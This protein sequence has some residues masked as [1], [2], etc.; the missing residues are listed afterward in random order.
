MGNET[1]S[2][3][4]VQN[5]NNQLFVNKSTINQMTEQLNDVI[6]NTIVKN[7]TNSGGSVINKQKLSFKKIKSK[8]DVD[9]GDIGQKQ[10]VAVTFD[11][12]NKTQARNDS[13]TQ[14]IQS[15][16]D[17]LK[18]NVSQEVITKMEGS[19][20][21]KIKTEVASGIFDKTDGKS[22]VVNTTNVTSIT[23]NVKNISSILKNRV[24]NN[25]TTD[26]VTNCVLNLDGQQLAEFVDIESTEGSVRIHNITQDQAV[27][28]VSKCGSVVDATNKIITETLNALD[29]KVDETNS[30]KTV[31]EEKG[32][33]ITDVEKTTW[34]I[35]EWLIYIIFG[36]LGLVVIAG[37]IYMVT[38]KGSPVRTAVENTL[39][40][41]SRAI[42]EA[43]RVVGRAVG[44]TG[45]AIGQAGGALWVRR[46]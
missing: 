24:E 40:Q 32:K 14:F 7:A 45:Q 18:N 39:G 37:L 35:S 29:I 15:A 10:V 1:S 20:D 23:E 26:V 2:T 17:N 44:R 33:A 27:T 8:G 43:E 19:A 11:T 9:I 34:P 6:A 38:T 21:A 25:F 3:A 16:L 42:G 30:I 4:S 28:A 41:A 31:T 36:I 5:I 22:E 13:A 12:M 46:I